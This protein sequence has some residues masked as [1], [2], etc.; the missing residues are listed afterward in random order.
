MPVADSSSLVSDTA[1]EPA[2][3]GEGHTLLC[4]ACSDHCCV[5]FYAA[6]HC[7]GSRTCPRRD[8]PVEPG[9]VRACMRA[10]Q[11]I[12]GDSSNRCITSLISPSTLSLS[13]KLSTPLRAR[14][15]RALLGTR[16]SRLAPLSAWKCRNSRPR[17]QPQRLASSSQRRFCLRAAPSPRA[18]PVMC[19]QARAWLAGFRH[20]PSNS[21]T[22]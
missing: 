22:G 4:S 3:V 16:R 20:G 7:G 19:P 9:G 17:A 6:V 2:H 11:A 14:P 5:I 1:P 13:R 8:C 10:V 18:L 12:F 15:T 21:A